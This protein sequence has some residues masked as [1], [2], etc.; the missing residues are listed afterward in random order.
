M[1]RPADLPC[2]AAIGVGLMLVAALM[3]GASP[4]ATARDGAR[5]TDAIVQVQATI[6]PDART[7]GAL[8]TRRQ[9]SGVVIDAAGL[10]LTVGHVV[11]EADAVTVTDH[12]GGAWPARIVAYDHESGF[13]L[14][15]AAPLPVPPI[16]LGRSGGLTDES[17]VLVAAY[18]D[19]RP[20]RIADRRPF[21]GYWE[22]LLDAALFTYPPHPGFAGAALIDG[23]GRLVGIG[24]LVVRDAAAP[25]DRRVLPGN[26]FIP[27][28]ALAD[29]FPDLLAHGR[30]A[31]P[32]R[33]WIGLYGMAL[34]DRVFVNHVA[35]G[36][37]AGKAGVRPGDLV[38]GIN[39]KPVSS[40]ADM[41]R[42][43]WSSGDAGVTVPVTVLRGLA[44]ETLDVVSIDRYRWLKLGRN[45]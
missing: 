43:L 39:G 7:A 31:G 18:G 16:A 35:D 42:A 9:G 8:G 37:P 22:Y 34:H 5:V 26:M 45:H 23:G 6:P 14:L 33:P 19:V 1:A 17:P 21:A 24:S 11:L 40:L 25:T 4:P 28:D 41:Y 30:R 2:R 36:G 38:V 3:T 12:A 10:V 27:I 20:A 29:P 32:Y 44:L 13:G 15:R